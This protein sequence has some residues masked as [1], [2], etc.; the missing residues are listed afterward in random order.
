V[1]TSAAT[2]QVRTSGQLDRQ[3]P[4]AL[5]VGAPALA[6]DR[7]ATVEIGQVWERPSSPAAVTSGRQS[8]V[9]A[10]WDATARVPA[11]TEPP[12]GRRWPGQRLPVPGTTE[13]SGG[14][15]PRG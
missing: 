2:S 14:A 6:I 1:Q 11:Q 4:T 5:L 7:G 15:A 12:A 10:R 9:F 3:A 13:R 8:V